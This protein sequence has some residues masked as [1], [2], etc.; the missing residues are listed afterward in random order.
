MR[1]APL[2]L[3]LLLWLSPLAQSHG[4]VEGKAALFLVTRPSGAD[5]VWDGRTLEKKTPVLLR[6]ITA[7]SHRLEVMRSGYASRVER[8]D[9]TGSEVRVV[10][11]AL[12]DGTFEIGFPSDG[13]IAIRGEGLEAEDRVLRLPEGRYGFSR[14]GGALRIEPVFPRQRLIDALHL[15][16]PILFGFAGLLTLDAIID[17]PGSSRPFPPAA[18]VT[19][20][21]SVAMLGVELALNVQKRRYLSE[22]SYRLDEATP[23]AAVLAEADEALRVGELSRALQALGRIGPEQP[24]FPDALYK[25]S[26]VHALAGDYEAALQGFDRIATDYPLPHLYDRAQKNAA[27]ILLRFDRFEESLLRLEAMV[28]ADPL[29]TREEI[30][31]YKAELLARWSD[32]HPE[33]RPRAVEAYRALVDHYGD[34][35]RSAR[36][37]LSLALLLRNGGESREA[38]EQVRMALD[39]ATESD[40]VERAR[41]LEQALRVQP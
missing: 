9:M 21:L 30:D 37:R 16:T 25:T 4:Q 35:N 24:A 29:Y 12:A 36:Y 32:R 1:P 23:D 3:A 14:N 6:D 13:R 10:K 31:S 8:I 2:P 19:Q 11:L 7:G 22:L 5:V 15:T 27:D 34:K 18:V 40:V 17:P 20:A 26:A 28:M 41:E 38:L 39:S 33:V